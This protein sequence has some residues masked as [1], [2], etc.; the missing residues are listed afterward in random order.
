[1]KQLLLSFSILITSVFQAQANSTFV[2]KEYHHIRQQGWVH[3]RCD[4][5]FS[6]DY[7]TFWCESAY[8][9]PSG[10]ATFKTSK[11]PG[12]HHVALVVENAEGTLKDSWRLNTFNG[13]TFLPI[14][15]AGAGGILALGHNH[16]AYSVETKQN[17]VLETGAFET[18]VD[19]PPVRECRQIWVN[20]SN[21][22]DCRTSAY[23]CR[24][25]DY[26]RSECER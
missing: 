1:M 14:P 8:L 3:V 12:L 24:Q 11:R 18:H 7:G 4:D 17:Q 22:F 16:I 9:S 21:L 6:Q 20:S 13:K 25:L 23:A 15:L 5:G 2:E 26:P 10:A 19:Q